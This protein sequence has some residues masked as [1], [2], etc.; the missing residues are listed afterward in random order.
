[1]ALMSSLLC[2]F[3]ALTLI[4]MAYCCLILLGKFIQQLV[5][6][7]LR[8]S[9]QQHIKDKFWN[10]VFYKFIFVFG[11]INVQYMDEVVLWCSWFSVLGFL[12]LLAQLCKDRFEYLSFSPTTPGWSHTRLLGLLVAIFSL[13]GFMF[14]I[15]IAVGFFGGLNTFA[16][17][18]AEDELKEVNPQLRGGRVENHLGK[19]TLSSPDRGSNLDLPVLSSRAAQHD[20]RCVQL[21]VQTLHVIFRY[22]L[23]LYDMRQGGGSGGRVWEKRGPVAYYAELG[24]E[25]AALLIDLVHHLHMLL[26]SNILLSMASLVICMQ[27]RFLFHEIQRRI[28]KHRNYLWVLSHMEQNYPMASSEEL[29]EN[30]DNC[31]ICWE[32][33][34]SARKLPCT[35]LFHNSCLQSWLE[36]DSSCPTCRMVLSIQSPAGLEAANRMEHNLDTQGENQA[37]PR[38][39]PN[40]FFHFDGS[41]YVSWL[42][43]FSVEVT[44][45]QLLRS[46]QAQPA[47]T[48]QLDA[49]A[50]QVQQLFPYLS[51]PTIVEDLRATRSVELTIENV[52]DG[53]VVAPPPMFQ[54]D[55]DPPAVLDVETVSA[56]EELCTT[57]ETH[58]EERSK[59]AGLV[60]I[61]RH[62]TLN[63]E[64]KG[65]EEQGGKDMV[66]EGGDTRDKH[67]SE[68]KLYCSRA[69]PGDLELAL[70]RSS[71]SM[72]CFTI[73][74]PLVVVARTWVGSVEL[75]EVNPHLR[76][77]RVENHLGTPRPV[78]SAEIRT[79]ISPSSAVELNTTSALANY[80]TGAGKKKSAETSTNLGGRFSKSSIERERILHLRKEQ[81]L[82][83]ARHR[84]M[85]RH[86]RPELQQSMSEDA[87]AR[88]RHINS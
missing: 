25:L 15:C 13:S 49:M 26:W 79:S 78:H 42:P 34:E 32:K 39:P 5:F 69:F 24:F 73:L 62:I 11:V 18:V 82:V 2:L 60:A 45:T 87:S 41:R 74:R 61:R 70:L 54:R 22:V 17:M 40:H 72:E 53:R 71:N 7:E 8:V 19:T 68:N 10:F 77:G 4:N 3:H 33:M 28:K 46:D 12:H 76:G 80:A 47:Q 84:Y 38:R 66:H 30:S 67:S 31:A 64:K 43:S 56:W 63:P 86:C 65:G 36:Q 6:G 51:L 9:E 57:S 35:H 14:L 20:K 55:S 27:L 21:S 44:H 52:L 16:F 75:E 88:H 37:T 83:S 59:S 81:L 48:S 29:S 85:E 23:H 50:R 1:M 58:Q